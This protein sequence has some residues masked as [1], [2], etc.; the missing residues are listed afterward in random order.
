[1]H[2]LLKKHCYS[3]QPRLENKC[4]MGGIKD[5][6]CSMPSWEYA[7]KLVDLYFYNYVSFSWI[8]C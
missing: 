2:L 8:K 1:V 7:S 4:Y 3:K 6:Q 5:S